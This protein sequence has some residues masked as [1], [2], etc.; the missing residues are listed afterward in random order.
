MRILFRTHKRGFATILSVYCKCLLQC[1][2]WFR[3][4]LQTLVSH[5]ENVICI[6]I[7]YFSRVDGFDVTGGDLF[8]LVAGVSKLLLSFIEVFT[9]R[10]K[11]CCNLVIIVQNTC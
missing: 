6:L 7:L 9:H 4:L 10:G 8:R 5:D 11:K 1:C 2:K 3:V